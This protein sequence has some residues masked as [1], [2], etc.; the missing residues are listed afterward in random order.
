M[1]P[2]SLT[3]LTPP[4]G[5]AG[6]GVARGAVG[7]VGAAERQPAAP[8]VPPARG[9]GLPRYRLCACMGPA[10]GMKQLHTGLHY[11]RRRGQ[12]R[13][14]EL[15]L[16]SA[17]LGLA[18]SG[19]L[20]PRVCVCV[21]VC[22]CVYV[23]VC[24][25]VHALGTQSLTH[26]ERLTCTSY[27]TVSRARHE[28]RPV[29]VKASGGGRCGATVFDGT[30]EPSVSRTVLRCARAHSWPGLPRGRGLSARG[31]SRLVLVVAKL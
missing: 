30:S 26:V 5:R 31:T 17:A 23:C 29:V 12:C 16:R 11:V 13:M 8:P 24:V 19:C 15:S 27:S 22:V 7:G 3:P 1:L 18:A 20:Q 6:P 28:G 4:P 25:C 21:C 9:K 14:L 2:G 10:S